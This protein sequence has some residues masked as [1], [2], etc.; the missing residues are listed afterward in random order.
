[1]TEDIYE[2]VDRYR[3][4]FR[5]RFARHTADL[6]ESL[7]RDSGVDERANADTVRRL[8]ELETAVAEAKTS[9]GWWKAARIAAVVVGAGCLVAAFAQ[10]LYWL[11]LVTVA[12]AVLVVRKLNPKISDV[13][14]RLAELEGARDAQL[15]K[16]WGE[17]APLNRLYRWEFFAQLV[18]RT[19]PRIEFDPYFSDGRLAELRESFG[20]N[21]DFNDDRSVLFAHSG[22]LN[23]NPFV[24]AR[25]LQHW[26]GQKT[27][28]G[29][30]QI[31]WT[32]RV[33]NSDGKWTTE[34]RHQTLHASVTKPHPEYADRPAVIYG[35]EA[36][37]DLT[38]SRAPSSL[39]GLEDGLFN[40]WRKRRA[41]KALEAKSRDLTDGKHF[42]VMANT[43]FDALFGATDRDHE[44]QFRLLFTPLA[45]Q[46]ML[47]VLK[48]QEVGFGDNFHFLKQH[49]L[50]VVVPGHLAGEDI[51][52][53]P[54]L[55]AR[56]ELADARQVFNAT[57]NGLFRS[58]YFALA[59]LL[60]VPLYQQHRSHADIYR[61]VHTRRSNFWEHESIA[62]YFGEHRFQHAASITRNL[63]KTRA[64]VQADGT[65]SVE[66]T[67]H[68]YRGVER[69]DYVPVRGGDGRVHN[70]PVHWIEHHPVR[71]SSDVL[72]HEVLP[73]AS[74]PSPT[75]GTA[76]AASAATATPAQAAW[77]TVFAARGLD[78]ERAHVRRSIA[79]TL[80]A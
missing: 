30:L 73:E 23:G 47:K 69:V 20:W 48:D 24:V 52:G 51:S 68:G 60:T 21:D 19:V 35:N 22:V 7:V 2:P 10:D 76:E 8:R 28:H 49:R 39:S 64:T 25:T 66:V 59:P 16:A 9:N 67:A 65:Q 26:M 50:N 5:E 42:T 80:L 57:Y 17:M 33:K 72:L 13:T 71:R 44:V 18:Q 79:A 31:S 4:E 46:E 58:L 37:P 12:C 1:M 38:F 3:D 53:D 75:G 55:F 74:P 63:L 78:P 54:A 41:V 40:N 36:A 56:Y 70:V 11:L 29:T 62:N 43:E 34:V 14:A 15:Q 45:Q 77:M 32:E 6:F 61:D 27:Y